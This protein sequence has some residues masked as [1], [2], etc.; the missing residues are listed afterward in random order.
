MAGCGGTEAL[1]DLMEEAYRG[2]GIEETD[3]SQASTVT[4]DA[5]HA[6]EINHARS[7][8]DGDDRWR[9]IQQGFG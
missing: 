5:Y 9:Y 2:A 3:E 1:L 7:L 6:G 8:L 4:H